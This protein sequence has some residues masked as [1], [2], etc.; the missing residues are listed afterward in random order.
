MARKS[1]VPDQIRLT[2]MISLMVEYATML[3]YGLTYG[4]AYA[5]TG[6]KRGS[7]HYRRLA[8]DFNLFFKVDGRWMYQR[9]SKAHEPL[10][11][12]WEFIGGTW[13]GRFRKRD[14]NHYSKG[15]RK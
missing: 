15:E 1:D 8:V 3:G 14:G 13:G 11:L 6:H 2:Q 12:F 5:K 9:S 10:G 7:Y 4:D